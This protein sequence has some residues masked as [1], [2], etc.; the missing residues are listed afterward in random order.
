MS[1]AIEKEGRPARAGR[2]WGALCVLLA[3]ALLVLAAPRLVGALLKVPGDAGL[4]GVEYN[5][6][7]TVG[8][9]DSLIDSRQAAAAWITSGRDSNAVGIAAM[10]LLGLMEAL[11]ARQPADEAAHLALAI[12]SLRAGLALQPAQP[13]AWQQLSYALLK[14]G[15]PGDIAASERAWRMAARTGP[16]EP[17]I[18]MARIGMGLLL[19]THMSPSTRQTFTLEIERAARWQPEALARLSQD[20]GADTFIRISLYAKPE[21]V[22]MFNEMARLP[23]AGSPLFP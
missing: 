8:T 7:Y 3:A 18:L 19:W 14:R 4:A 20:F 21:L 15:G 23:E 6:P 17:N 12:S 1:A 9:L 11:P 5:R 16:N 13:F 2:L 22:A 10:R